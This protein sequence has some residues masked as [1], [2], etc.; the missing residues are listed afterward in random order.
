MAAP[1]NPG[2]KLLRNDAA[3]PTQLALSL[4]AKAGMAQATIIAT[5]SAVTA[6]TEKIRRI[7]RYL[8]LP[9]TWACFFLDI[10]L[11]TPLCASVSGAER[12]VYR[13]TARAGHGVGWH[14]ILPLRT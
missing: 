1:P 9:R 3:C 5:I 8:L 4:A 6:R 14:G 10:P 2:L 7:Q 13:A 11:F 12:F